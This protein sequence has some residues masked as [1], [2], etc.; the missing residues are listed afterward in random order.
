MKTAVNK[1]LIIAL[2]ILFHQQL[3]AQ[4]IRV[5]FAAIS[6]LRIVLAPV[7]IISFEGTVSN[8]K[9]LLNWTVDGNQEADQ[10]EV[11]RSSNGKTF[12]MAALVFGTGKPDMDHY[13]FYEKK[14]KTK[15]SYRI[16]VILK[17][18]AIAYSPV[19]K[20]GSDRNTIK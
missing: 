3:T 19:I 4:N 18:G 2:G 12:V 13:Q 16:K 15:M 5:P 11:E 14:T 8:N 7:K 17:N 20:A 1:F 6:S 9:V 10:F